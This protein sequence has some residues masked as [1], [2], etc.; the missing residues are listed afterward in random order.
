MPAR[1]PTV[2]YEA[3]DIVRRVPTTK[4]YLNF[5]GRPWKVPE[6]SRGERIAARSLAVRLGQMV[7]VVRTRWSRSSK[8]S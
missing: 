2:E 1:L 7:P 3:H 6:A 5:K 8:H 4:P